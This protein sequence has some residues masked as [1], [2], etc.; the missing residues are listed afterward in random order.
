MINDF[1]WTRKD[2]IFQL[3]DRGTDYRITNEY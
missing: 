3:L 1:D 2:Y